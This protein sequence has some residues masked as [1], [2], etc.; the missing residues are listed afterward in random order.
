MN[1]A[2]E[3]RIIRHAEHIIAALPNGLVDEPLDIAIAA[4]QVLLDYT[5]GLAS[6]AH[7]V[8]RLN[9]LST[10]AIDFD[11]KRSGDSE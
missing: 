9:A 2:Q 1:K 3:K 5:V 11:Q 10:K 4:V 8:R 7:L 6:T